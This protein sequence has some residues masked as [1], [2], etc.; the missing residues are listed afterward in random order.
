MLVNAAGPFAG[1]LAARAGLEVPVVPSRRMVF[2]TAPFLPFAHPTPLIVDL[3]SGVYLRSE[4]NRFIFGKSNPDESPGFNPAIDWGWLNRVLELALPR[5]PFLERAGLD[6][7]ACWVGHYALTPD[8]LPVLGRMPQAPTFVNACGFSGHG[9]QHA[10][11]TGIIVA[12]EV[13]DGGTSRFDLTD[14]RIERFVQGSERPE[15]NIV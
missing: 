13:F 3:D 2:A 11:A 14:F 5:F 10:P 1:E 8:H 15:A 9:V 4:G 7:R 12:D 6:R